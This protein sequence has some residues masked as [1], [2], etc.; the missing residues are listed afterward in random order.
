[1]RLESKRQ[2][3]YTFARSEVPKSID[4][5]GLMVRL[6]FSENIVAVKQAK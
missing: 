2:G 4:K 6:R 3:G 5:T 1:M